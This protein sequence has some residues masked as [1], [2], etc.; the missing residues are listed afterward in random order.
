MEKSRGLSGQSRSAF[1]SSLIDSVSKEQR[2]QRIYQIYL[3]ATNNKQNLLNKFEYGKLLGH[4]QIEPS[5]AGKNN[6]GQK[7]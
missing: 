7:S 4:G 5:G 1:I 2:W 6:T 3:S